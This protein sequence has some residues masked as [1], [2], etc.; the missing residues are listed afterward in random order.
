[1]SYYTFQK[2]FNKSENFFKECFNSNLLDMNLHEQD[3][4]FT[5]LQ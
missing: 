1:M 3:M 2:V 5:P 4:N